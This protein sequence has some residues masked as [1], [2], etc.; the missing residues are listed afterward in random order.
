MMTNNLWCNVC[1]NLG[2]E[3]YCLRGVANYKGD[4]QP[5]HSHSLIRACVIRILESITF[6]LAA[7]EISI[8]ELFSVAALAGLY[9]TFSESPK[10][11]L[12]AS[13]PIFLQ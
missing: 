4:D 5:V 6:K 1:A 13:R 2:R 9:L 11:A 3:K 8:A 12:F 10:T 7:G